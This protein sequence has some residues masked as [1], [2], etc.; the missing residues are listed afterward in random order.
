MKVCL[1]GKDPKDYD[2][3]KLL[4]HYCVLAANERVQ[5]KG[6]MLQDD[7]AGRSTSCAHAERQSQT[8]DNTVEVLCLI[9]C[10]YVN[11][12]IEEL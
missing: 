1:V 9:F 5:R 12:C 10:M 6:Q 2:A 7:E 8:E 3:A 11:I 4:L